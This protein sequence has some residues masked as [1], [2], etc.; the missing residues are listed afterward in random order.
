MK[1]VSIKVFLLTHL[2]V[3]VCTTLFAQETTSQHEFP[4]ENTASRTE[5]EAEIDTEA[6]TSKTTTTKA[7]TELTKSLQKPKPVVDNQ[8]IAKKVE[9]DVVSF[10]FLYY[11][12]QRFKSSDIIED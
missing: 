6:A 7:E 12:I 4:S 10:N 8:K 2:L 3:G 5:E 1:K 9:D 11:V